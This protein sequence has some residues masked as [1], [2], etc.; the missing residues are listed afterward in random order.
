MSSRAAILFSFFSAA[1][2]LFLPSGRL[3]LEKEYVFGRSVVRLVSSLSDGSQATK[4]LKAIA[5]STS[6]PTQ[7]SSCFS[8][9]RSEIFDLKNNSKINLNRCT[10]DAQ[11]VFLQR[12]LQNLELFHTPSVY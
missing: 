4:N 1:L 11:K 12:I 3:R 6:W 10:K 7:F 9:L 8:S 5:F 2:I